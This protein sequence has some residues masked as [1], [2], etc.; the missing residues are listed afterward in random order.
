MAVVP[1]CSIF[2]ITGALGMYCSLVRLMEHHIWCWISFNGSWRR[3][4]RQQV[5]LPE[6]LPPGKRCSK[7]IKRAHRHW[8]ARCVHMALAQ[9][10]AYAC[11][12]EVI[13][14][15]LAGV[16][17]HFSY[18]SLRTERVQQIAALAKQYGFGVRVR[19]VE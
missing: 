15:G 5:N 13:L 4:R 2:P 14:L 11:I 6:N 9:G 3:W 16:R 1:S 7:F 8:Q 17:Q 10:D 12:S 19:E 18:G